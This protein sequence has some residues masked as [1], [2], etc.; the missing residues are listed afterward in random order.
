MPQPIKNVQFLLLL[1]CMPISAEYD[2]SEVITVS[3][4]F[5]GLVY[6]LALMVKTATLGA[7][8]IRPMIKKQFL[9]CTNI[10]KL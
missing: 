6:F 9:L 5:R 4:R 1:T 2:F 8:I 7:T 10:L 3:V